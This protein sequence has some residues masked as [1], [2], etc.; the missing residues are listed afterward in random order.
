MTHLP[1]KSVWTKDFARKV[2]EGCIAQTGIP[3]DA[4]IERAGLA[5]A[6]R[7]RNLPARLSRTV[8]VLAGIGNNGA[9]GMAAARNLHEWGFDVHVVLVHDAAHDKRRTASNRL[10]LHILERL[11]VPIE[12][13]VFHLIQQK[14]TQQDTIIIDSVLGLGFCGPLRD[15]PIKDALIECAQLKQKTV[16]AVDLPSGMSADGADATVPLRADICITFG[17]G[18]ICHYLDPHRS[19]CG[20]LHVEDVG[21]VQSIISSLTASTPPAI[22][23]ADD[24][25]Q[26]RKSNPFLRMPRDAHKFQRGHVLVIGGSNGKMGAPLLAAMSALRTGSGW[27][28][29]ARTGAQDSTLESLHPEL[30]WEDLQVSDFAAIAQF[31]Q[32]R[33]VRSVVVG[34]GWI[35]QEL[36]DVAIESIRGLMAHGIKF[37]FDAGAT[38]GL[39]SLVAPRPFS[40]NAAIATPHPGE[41]LKLRAKQI[42]TK[43]IG[44]NEIAQANSA[45]KSL[46]MSMIYKSSTPLLFS[47][48]IGVPVIFPFTD[49]RIA[50]A[51]SGDVFAGCLGALS[52]HCSDWKESVGAAF[53]QMAF[54]T[55]IASVQFG[56]KGITATDLINAIGF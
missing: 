41:W 22:E 50:K 12:T 3:Q 25:A 14:F 56:N 45:A 18:K 26:W 24:D 35:Q 11:R 20:E 23:I 15:G 44:L 48:N 51:G 32:S 21:F 29:V 43:V 17:Q 1:V 46:G 5:I 36:D 28:T 39:E 10:Q 52:M 19:H 27:V 16:V 2:D 30:T 13:Y 53:A 34:P 54:A 42:P 47:S 6:M 31:C 49:E 8:L 33:N 38:H 37:V 9:D 4:I 40:G 7:I 55:R